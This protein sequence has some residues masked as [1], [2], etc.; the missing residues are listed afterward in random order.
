MDILARN[1]STKNDSPK[2]QKVTAKRDKVHSHSRKS[3]DETK[4]EKSPSS[5]SSSSRVLRPQAATL[6]SSR[7][8]ESTCDIF[9]SIENVDNY[10]KRERI[11]VSAKDAGKAAR[12][13]G[14]DASS[15]I[16]EKKNDSCSEDDDDDDVVQ[17]TQKPHV[18]RTRRQITVPTSRLQSQDKVPVG[19]KPGGVDSEDEANED[20][21]L[22]ERSSGVDL[23]E[24]DEDVDQIL[25]SQPAG[26]MT[27][28][29]R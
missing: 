4:R 2:L 1:N 15:V 13:G 28:I 7:A 5:L 16:R 29:R 18:A 23:Y 26:T 24:T 22:F 10:T 11:G 25:S 20:D 8:R 9:Y 3:S 27:L 17:S 21:D 12:E 19:L 14:I 6:H